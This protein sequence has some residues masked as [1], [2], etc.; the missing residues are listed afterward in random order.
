[1]IKPTPPSVESCLAS[2]ARMQLSDNLRDH[3][4]DETASGQLTD[5]R[6]RNWLS[7]AAEVFR[8]CEDFALGQDPALVCKARAEVI[9]AENARGAVKQGTYKAIARIIASGPGAETQDKSP[10]QKIQ[11]CLAHST[12]LIKAADAWAAE[13]GGDG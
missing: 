8:A 12:A 11:D 6:L 9:L 10:T 1:M 7:F 4:T 2:M 13:G 3:I 5:D